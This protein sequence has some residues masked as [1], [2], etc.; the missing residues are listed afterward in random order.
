MKHNLVLLACLSA[1]GITAFAQDDA[2]YVT[3]MKTVG[4]TG[5]SL[6]KN[7]EAKNADGAAADAKKLQEVFG[8]V[9]EYWV[10][11]GTDDASTFAMT[12]HDAYGEVATEAAAGKFD[13]AS[14]SLKKAS[15]TCGGCHS[16]HREKAPDGSWK[17]K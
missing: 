9:H 15:A 11:K 8:H 13:D 6:R 12:A 1:L 17:I 2:A 14:A 4:S 5:G 10:K 3:W 16:A 7:L